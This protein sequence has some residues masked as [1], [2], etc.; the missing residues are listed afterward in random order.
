MTET[1]A[2][3]AINAVTDRIAALLD[4]RITPPPLLKD[5]G[6]ILY[7]EG[8]NVV[9]QSLDQVHARCCADV[10][11]ECKA[12]EAAEGYR[13]ASRIYERVFEPDFPNFDADAVRISCV[14]PLSA[15]RLV[16]RTDDVIYAFSL[17]IHY[18]F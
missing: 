3:A 6:V 17:R 11:I 13:T 18:Y 16:S 9:S 15:P 5:G 10:T 7:P 1:G 12:R 2:E 14:K 4:I 8:G